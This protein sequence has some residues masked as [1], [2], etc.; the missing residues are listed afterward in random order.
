[1]KKNILLP[2][3][4]RLLYKR[5][6]K[7]GMDNPDRETKASRISLINKAMGRNNLMD[8]TI[9]NEKSEHTKPERKRESMSQNY[10]IAQSPTTWDKVTTSQDI[11][12]SPRQTCKSDQYNMF[13]G[14]QRNIETPNDA[15]LLSTLAEDTKNGFLQVVR[16]YEHKLYR[17]AT[18]YRAIS[19]QDAEDI[20]QETF[21]R[22]Y[23]ALK[24]YSG[25]RIRTLNMQAWLYTIADNVARNY[26]RSQYRK[27][28]YSS[29]SLELLPDDALSSSG[30]M[31]AIDEADAIKQ[32]LQRVSP[33]YR[34]CL[35]LQE[36]GGFS[37]R[38]IADHLRITPGCVGAYISRGRQQFRRAYQRSQNER[39]KEQERETDHA[40]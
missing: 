13:N 16:T 25:E 15:N 33:Q 4:A 6:K 23:N 3:K 2:R 36:Q 39:G 20:V 27:G 5:S 22:A 34:L 37:Q 21:L 32:S 35:V 40:Y 10:H 31:R 11:A 7:T 18:Y 19:E 24:Q 28:L 12:P 9:Q 1:M 38:E 30:Q 26:R 8:E 14:D 17:F 29:L